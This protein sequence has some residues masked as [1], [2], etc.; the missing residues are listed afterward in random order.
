MC[1]GYSAVCKDK[2][3]DVGLVLVTPVF[4]GVTMTVSDYRIGIMFASLASS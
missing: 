2:F 1:P 4:A 3:K